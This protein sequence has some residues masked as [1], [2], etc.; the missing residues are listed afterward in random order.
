MFTVGV[1]NKFINRVKAQF[2]HLQA[3][4]ASLKKNQHFGYPNSNTEKTEQNSLKRDQ[5]SI[6]KIIL[7]MTKAK[8]LFAINSQ[9]NF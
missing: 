7:L 8:K 9:S 4:T 3:F 2:L 5:F 1:L 6:I